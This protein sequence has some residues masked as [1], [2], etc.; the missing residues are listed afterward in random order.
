LNKAFDSF[1]QI[2]LVGKRMKAWNA[3]VYSAV[4]FSLVGALLG[5]VP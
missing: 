1:Y 2:R 4:K 5:G 3:K